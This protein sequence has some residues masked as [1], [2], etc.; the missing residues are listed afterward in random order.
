VE[1]WRTR[2]LL[3]A[4]VLIAAGG[5]VAVVLAQTDSSATSAGKA[6]TPLLL[7]SAQKPV[8]QLVASVSSMA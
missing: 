4:L 6:S 1:R 5:V 3:G 8:H 2:A 7:A